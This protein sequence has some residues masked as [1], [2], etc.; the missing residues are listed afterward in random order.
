M[1]NA[2]ARALFNSDAYGSASSI[3]FSHK[4]KRF[5]TLLLVPVNIRAAS[6]FLSPMMRV[7]GSCMV[8]FGQYWDSHIC[9][10]KGHK[11]RGLK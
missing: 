11:S 8:R 5:S 2:F 4:I 1:N 9:N 6:V 7:M 3:P 10:N